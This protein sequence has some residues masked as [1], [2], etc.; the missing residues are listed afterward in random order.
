LIRTK[1]K[2]FL[3]FNPDDEYIWIKTELED[4]R[5]LEEKDVRVIV[6]TYKDNPYLSPEEIKEIERLEK[7]D[8]VYWNIY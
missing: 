7:T 8:P 3:D 1:Y 5:R 6:S 2:V 4:K